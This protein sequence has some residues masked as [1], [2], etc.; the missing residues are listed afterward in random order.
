MKVLFKPPEKGDDDTDYDYD[1]RGNKIRKFVRKW[2]GKEKFKW[3][4]DKSFRGSGNDGKTLQK[5]QQV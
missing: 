3:E 5:M 2:S 1:S 4:E